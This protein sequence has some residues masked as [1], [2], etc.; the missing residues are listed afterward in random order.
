MCGVDGSELSRRAARMARTLAGSLG[1]GLMFVHV[2]EP[3]AQE[4]ESSSIAERLGR[5][6][7]NRTS[8]DR[9][10]T[11]CVDVGTP[12]ERLLARAEEV[13]ASMVVVGAAAPCPL[14]VVPP[15]AVPLEPQGVVVQGGIARF[16]LGERPAT[17][18]TAGSSRA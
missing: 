3:G 6:S 2:V 14:V 8:A 4:S 15:D 16:D 12:V 9:G 11:W 18:P 7:A 1:L 10:A 5:L 13:G 17:G